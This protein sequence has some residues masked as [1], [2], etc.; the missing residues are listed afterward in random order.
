MSS[1]RARM[2]C[3]GDGQGAIMGVVSAP[4]GPQNTVQSSRRHQSAPRGAV[5]A[6]ETTASAPRQQSRCQSP[7]IAT[8]AQRD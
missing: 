1:Y 5:A 8:L 4:N 7:P 3:S 2:H 6:H